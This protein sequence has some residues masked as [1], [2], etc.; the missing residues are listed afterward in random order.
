[1]R[2]AIRLGHELELEVVAEGVETAE[3]YSFLAE[4]GCTKVQGYLISKPVSLHQVA[5][6]NVS[7]NCPLSMAV[8]LVHMAIMDHVQWRKSMV[9]YALRNAALVPD[10]PARQE[11]NYPSLSCNAGALG[12]WCVTDGQVFTGQPELRD[13]SKA[14]MA[15]HAAAAHIVARIQSGACLAEISGPLSDMTRASL[16]LLECLSTLENRGL[17][18]FYRQRLN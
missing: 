3:Q 13:M 10:A 12:R 5:Q 8:G 2:S 4:A 6:H 11:H 17:A 14:D 16:V 15:V 9:S 1:V 7:K 18:A